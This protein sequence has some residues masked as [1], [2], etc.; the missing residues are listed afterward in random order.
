MEWL[1]CIACKNRYDELGVRYTCDVCGG[2]LSVE[3]DTHI[4]R[5][6][7]DDRRTS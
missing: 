7:F 1:E 5:N 4:D 6:S 2:L 3:R